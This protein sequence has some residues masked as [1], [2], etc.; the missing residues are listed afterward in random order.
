MQILAN[1]IRI[2][3]LIFS[4][5]LI[6]GCAGSDKAPG[7]EPSDRVS[8]GQV[9]SPKPQPKASILQGEIL[10]INDSQTD[11]PVGNFDFKNFSYSSDRSNF[12]VFSIKELAFIS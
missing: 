2:L 5:A 9:L 8:N 7:K 3:T 12:K 1:N 6:S 10:G 11:S 4:I